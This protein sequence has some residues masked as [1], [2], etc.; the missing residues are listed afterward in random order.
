MSESNATDTSEQSRIQSYNSMISS[1]S[2]LAGE[3]P[4]LKPEERPLASVAQAHEHMSRR[5]PS[6]LRPFFSLRVQLTF[7][8]GLLSILMV[9]IGILLTYRQTTSLTILFVVV[10]LAALG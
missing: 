8:Y 3:S 2:A 1:D 6:W 5:A 4:R 7:A 9:I 10:F